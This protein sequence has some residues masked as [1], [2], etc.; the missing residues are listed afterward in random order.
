MRTRFANT[1][2]DVAV[3]YLAGDAGGAAARPRR[4]CSAHP[5][6]PLAPGLLATG[7]EGRQELVRRQDGDRA[8]GEVVRVPC[9]KTGRLDVH[10]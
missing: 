2:R 1:G 6:P 8:E 10:G 4:A 9:D 7:S 5:T 3:R